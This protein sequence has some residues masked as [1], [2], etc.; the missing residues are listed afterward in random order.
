MYYKPNSPYHC[1]YVNPL[2]LWTFAC[3]N[4]IMSITWSWL[5]WVSENVWKS[6]W[7]SP[8]CTAETWLLAG[9]RGQS[10][11]LSSYSSNI[12]WR[13]AFWTPSVSNI[14]YILHFE[15]HWML[16]MLDF[17]QN[18]KSRL[19]LYPCWKCESAKQLWSRTH[20]VTGRQWGAEG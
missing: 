6:C 17:S 19:C 9:N 18:K 16:L 20:S 2:W 1:C 7:K 10:A 3:F 11:R 15:T 14:E 12:K 4:V 8:K 5:I 13:D